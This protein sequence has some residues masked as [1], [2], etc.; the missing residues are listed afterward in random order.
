MKK[1]TSRNGVPIRLTD[2]RWSHITESHC[3]M[4]GYYYEILECVEDP[5]AVYEGKYEE[6]IGMKEIQENKHCGDVQGSERKR[7]IRDN[8]LHYK[9]KRTV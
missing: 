1:V 9:Q 7:W 4:A 8:I 2:E 6:L 5:D 3:E